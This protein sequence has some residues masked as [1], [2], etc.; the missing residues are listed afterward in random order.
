[1]LCVL[2][3]KN[4]GIIFFQKRLKIIWKDKIKGVIFATPNRLKQIRNDVV[5]TLH[6][7]SEEH[8]ILKVIFYYNDSLS[9]IRLKVL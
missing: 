9:H 8:K 3:D 4:L 6:A 5:E 7:M 2:K 1:L